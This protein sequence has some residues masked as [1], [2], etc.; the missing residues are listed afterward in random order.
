MR[1][2]AQILVG[3]LVGI[4]LMAAGCK[5]SMVINK[6]DYSQPI[7]SVV[8]PNEEGMVVDQ[9]YGLKFNIMPL[10]YAETQDTSSVTTT[11]VRFIRGQSGL[12]YLTAPTY[13]HVYVMAPEKNQLKF[14][15][16]YKL[17]QVGIAKPAFN[18]R[19]DFIQLVDRT[20]GQRY[21]LTPD[22][23]T[24]EEM[25]ITNMEDQS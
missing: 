1:Q 19:G 5:Q 7:E 9:R 24:K 16:K 14:E 2:Q 22:E 12:Y 3:I 18:Q 8:S 21:R 6:V 13:Q 17:G 15:K 20:T 10:Q 25:E 11:Q 23:M 4:S